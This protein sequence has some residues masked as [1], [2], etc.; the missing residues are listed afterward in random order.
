M[1][2]WTKRGILLG[3]PFLFCLK[4]YF[5]CTEIAL[6]LTRGRASFFISFFQKERDSIMDSYDND[7]LILL[8]DDDLF[9]VEQEESNVALLSAQPEKSECR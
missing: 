3:A 9:P 4:L 7:M 6:P 5:R 1:S 8:L 2:I